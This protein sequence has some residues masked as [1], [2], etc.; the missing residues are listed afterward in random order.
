MFASRQ[1]R[2]PS[3]AYW[4]FEL[5]PL[6][7]PGFRLR[8]G[9][10]GVVSVFV[11]PGFLGSAVVLPAFDR[12]RLGGSGL[13]VVPLA[14]LALVVAEKLRALRDPDLVLL[15]VQLL[16]RHR[17]QR[18]GVGRADLLRQDVI[19]ERLDQRIAFGVVAGMQ[20]RQEDELRVGLQRRGLVPL[21]VAEGPH[22]AREEQV[23]AAGLDRLIDFFLVDLRVC[24]DSFGLVLREG[25]DCEECR[26]AEREP[27]LH[28]NLPNPSGVAR[29][30]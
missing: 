20:Q 30:P 25:R 4:E 15:R 13:A 7:G 1:A 3:A 6:G 18:R 8:I 29:R 22:P 14:V 5:S 2:R 9:I 27:L 23:L 11:L 10:R 16:Q 24:G 26:Q 12:R 21:A 17:H 28:N 19:D